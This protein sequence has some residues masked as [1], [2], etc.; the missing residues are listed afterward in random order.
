MM[1]D[2]PI[3]NFLNLLLGSYSNQKQSIKNP[4][5]FAYIN[6]YF[7][8]IPWSIFESPFL[9]SEQ[10][11][12]YSPWNPYRQSLHRVRV[13]NKLFII[14]NYKIEDPIR[15]AGAGF[16]PELLESLRDSKPKRRVGCSMHFKETGKS[17]YKG[18]IE[19]SGSC[20]I[21]HSGRMTYLS[22]KVKLEKNSF[23]IID[24]GY[25]VN[26][27]RKIWGSE[28]GPILFEKILGCDIRKSWLIDEIF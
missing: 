4:R 1:K 12:N 18:A 17:A 9:Y 11:Y 23:E 8:P 26:T 24:E 28:N 10:S 2:D 22:S 25:E 15:V 21:F 5:L 16:R 20:L 7:I 13:E 3:I 27:N 6:L 19:Q 14:D